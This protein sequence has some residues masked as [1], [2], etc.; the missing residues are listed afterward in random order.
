MLVAVANPL[1]LTSE[2]G[3]SSGG[4]EVMPPTKIL[5]ETPKFTLF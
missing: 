1:G 3:R 5:T 4:N 2:Q